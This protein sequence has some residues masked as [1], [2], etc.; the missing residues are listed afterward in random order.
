M[1]S[2]TSTASFPHTNPWNPPRVSGGLPGI[3]HLVDFVRDVTGL[4]R[5]ARAECGDIAGLRVGNKDMI[6][7]TGPRAQERYFRASD[8]VFSQREAYQ[9]MVPVF[10]QGVVYDATPERMNEQLKLLLLALQGPRMKHYAPIFTEE[11]ERSVADWGESGVVDFYDFTQKLTGY[12]STHCFFGAEFRHEMT[13][14]FSAVYHD[15]ER[16]II[17]LAYINPNLPIPTFRARDRARNKL[18]SM[19]E[20][21]LARRRAAGTGGT[22]LFQTLMDAS[23][24]DGTR[25]SPHEITG[26]LVATMFAGHHT[27]SVTA[28]WTMIELLQHPHEMQRVVDELDTKLGDRPLDY[29]A[30]RDI[31]VTDR[32]IR[33]ALRIHPPLYM[34]AREVLQDYNTDGFVIPKGAWVLASPLIGHEIE[35]VFANATQ[36][37]P[38]R[39]AEPRR[40]DACPYSYISFGA[41]RHKCMGNNFALLQI[42]AIFATLLRK[43]T[44]E[45]YGDPIRTDFGGMVAGP[46]QPCRVRYR[47]RR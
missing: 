45:L 19:I 24:S 37:D 13:D 15:L 21:L 9:M 39:L 29:R 43:Y 32:A 28:A 34:L 10:G 47:V 35:T 20:D 4:M 22:D 27:S 5:R 26:M 17:P 33:E 42:K 1:S 11:V 40:E 8:D 7:F 25:L 16:S 2:T 44:F 30:L 14:E 18:G 46:E 38:D 36:F 12:T 41:G 6:L 23:Y 31:E 3:G